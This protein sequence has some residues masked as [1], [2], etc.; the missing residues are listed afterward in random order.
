MK[1]Y[2]LIYRFCWILCL[3]LA[4]I[5]S[6]EAQRTDEV[7]I[8]FEN[9]ITGEAQTGNSY[10]AWDGGETDAGAWIGPGE[11]AACGWDN[12]GGGNALD[13]NTLAAPFNNVGAGFLRVDLAKKVLVKLPANMSD[14][15]YIGCLAKLTGSSSDYTIAQKT[16]TFEV[17]ADE[18]QSWKNV[19]D[20]VVNANYGA[21]TSLW[22]INLLNKVEQQNGKALWLRFYTG[23]AKLHIV[24][25]IRILS[26]SF[27]AG[28]D[29]LEAI[30]AND[31]IIPRGY[32]LGNGKW[33]NATY[34][35]W[36]LA[37]SQGDYNSYYTEKELAVEPNHP[38]RRTPSLVNAGE[39]A[40][41]M[42]Y[43]Y[44][45]AS[46][47]HPGSD[48]PNPIE[49]WSMTS[50]DGGH[51][52][53]PPVQVAAFDHL[54]RG[55]N[56]NAAYGTLVYDHIGERLWATIKNT[57]GDYDYNNEVMKIPQYGNKFFVA[58]SDDK[59]L[60]WSSLRDITQ[61]VNDDGNT[62]LS[63]GPGNGITTR[64]GV[65]IMPI[66]QTI[67]GV[68]QSGIIYSQDGGVS[69]NR[70]KGST[71]AN[72]NEAQIVELDNG[73]IMMSMRISSG[74][75]FRAVYVTDDLGDT[76]QPLPC[77]EQIYDII[78][79]ASLQRVFSKRDGYDQSVIFHTGPGALTAGQ[80]TYLTT[81]WSF[82]EGISWGA[83]TSQAVNQ[84]GRVRN[85]QYACLPLGSIGAGYSAMAMMS[86]GSLSV[87]YEDP[88]GGDNSNAGVADQGGAFF[89]APYSM[90]TGQDMPQQSERPVI[91]SFNRTLLAGVEDDI[92]LSLAD[93]SFMPISGTDASD[94][95]LRIACGQHYV[96]D[97]TA[98]VAIADDVVAK[99][100]C[101]VYITY[102]NG[103]ESLEDDVDSDYFSIPISI[104]QAQNADVPVL[105]KSI[106]FSDIR[107]GSSFSIPLNQHFQSADGSRIIYAASST[108]SDVASVGIN[109]HDELIITGH[110]E[111]TTDISIEASSE[112][113]KGIISEFSLRVDN[114]AG[115]MVQFN[116]SEGFSETLAT[117][118][119]KNAGYA[120]QNPVT[121]SY[122]NNW[123]F[124]RA[125]R[126]YGTFVDGATTNMSANPNGT[127]AYAMY[128]S[129]SGHG[130]FTLEIN[131][132]NFPDGIGGL[133]F[134][135]YAFF[136]Q[137]DITEGR[138]DDYSD[139][140]L[141]GPGAHW[142]PIPDVPVE[143]GNR[144]PSTS[145]GYLLDRVL[146]L[147][148]S[149][150]D[151]VTWKKIAN[152][153]P[154][155]HAEDEKLSTQVSLQDVAPSLNGNIWLKFYFSSSSQK[156]RLGTM[157]GRGVIFD[158][159]SIYSMKQ[160]ED[161]VVIPTISGDR[162]KTALKPKV[163]VAP[164]V[165]TNGQCVIQRSSDFQNSD[166]TV[167]VYDISG[168][169]ILTKGT[170][171]NGGAIQLDLGNQNKGLYLIM[172]TDA[173]T[174]RCLGT[175]K[176]VVQ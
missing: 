16:L 103:T 108:D 52:W 136:A 141:N 61:Q 8:T 93:F 68:Q 148:Y 97:H 101:K 121:D 112:D 169:L 124:G 67:G 56:G 66:Y 57:N 17:S 70:G 53:E 160:E 134:D 79:Q 82:D 45:I 175:E 71:Y 65:I 6:T 139:A 117:D 122:G 30:D 83:N 75:N 80:R 128:R 74:A 2:P 22:E 161:V 15:S 85:N 154:E 55:S 125:M 144:T 41:V 3:L 58:H 176:V 99:A 129:G 142:A 63:P 14:V 151:G 54:I 31:L 104:I 127:R 24:D 149:P 89:R 166:L 9:F 131:S 118:L 98:T 158:N 4:G 69:W 21:N 109:E 173:I 100:N 157:K 105:T 40:L 168:K 1:K 110:S 39:D 153:Y 138:N 50:L 152:W 5:L 77:N 111:G 81:R 126:S 60:T 130:Y 88:L 47:Y 49:T 72:T 51:T 174:H 44:R 123:V 10:N 35:S 87:V 43:E 102:T 145:S 11:T 171:G 147:S 37:N 143:Y 23:E 159:L 20:V 119:V 155:F 12:D 38:R 62:T 73:Q 165:V 140:G 132:A 18:G 42:L 59:G 116:A 29:Q 48:P 96:T 114:S 164:T 36:N 162:N 172:I 26:S 167:S 76:W 92:S 146:S 135:M 107:V 19:G 95:R 46:M 90:I 156:E 7:Y 113:G 84:F 170:S 91:N 33:N 28:G 150:D 133:M 94:Y 34:F 106:A 32:L 13:G 163:W 27:D 120:S 115:V 78:C 25:N 86:D 137:T 64:D